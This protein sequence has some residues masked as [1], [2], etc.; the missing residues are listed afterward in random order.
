[1]RHRIVG[2]SV[3]F[4]NGIVGMGH[5]DF[6]DYSDHYGNDYQSDDT[7]SQQRH[8]YT[9]NSSNGCM[10]E[11]KWRNKNSMFPTSKMGMSYTMHA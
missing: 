6:S 3:V 4:Q 5:C 1:M 9:N 8:Y 7:Q 11:C 2:L 10:V